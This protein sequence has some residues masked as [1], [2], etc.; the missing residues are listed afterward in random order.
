MKK[1]T[2]ISFW[3]G[4]L[5][6]LNIIF[7]AGI[8]ISPSKMATFAGPASFL[9][10]LCL[11]LVLLPLVWAFAYAG[12]LFDGEGGF[13][14]YCGQSLG[15]TAGFL[16]AWS[17]LLGYMST[18]SVITIVIRD[19]L[20][21]YG[22]FWIA[23]DYPTLTA[24]GIILL[25]SSL[26][27]F[28]LGAISKIQSIGTVI[29]I[30][31]LLFVIALIP[32]FPYTGIS[33]TPQD[34]VGIR[35]TIPFIIFAFFGIEICCNIS[36]LMKGGVQQASRAIFT[37]FAMSVVIYTLFHFGLLGIMGA[38]GL[39][40]YGVS[41]FPKF[42]G[43]SAPMTSFMQSFISFMILF[44]LLNAE[45]GLILTNV[46]NLQTLISNKLLPAHSFF[47]VTN[48]AHRPY[49]LVWLHALIMFGMVTLIAKPDIMMV[50]TSLG[51][52]GAYFLHALAVLVE[53][54]RRRYYG[55]IVLSLLALASCVV[56]V[57]Y[58]WVR[59][60]DNPL[61]VS[62]MVVGLILGLL[63]YKTQTKNQTA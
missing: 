55:S 59:I 37:A 36:H 51:I 50:L 38:P 46:T 28:G 21:Q 12:S 62:P 54:C 48:R 5:M 25:F 23:N 57:Y 31:P 8:F 11:G 52:C 56:M 22:A 47:G 45:Y 7:G 14:Q 61:Y 19:E 40:D 49:R 42:L 43:L 35:Y 15:Q 32:F 1:H 60:S 4:V 9:G 63:L 16:A 24:A 20:M 33:I 53:C 13:Y 30:L 3:G 10:W 34:I 58:S 17:Y 44:T 6:T 41:A 2:T 39:M 29:K 18:A 26:N 27:L